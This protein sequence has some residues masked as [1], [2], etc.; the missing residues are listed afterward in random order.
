MSKTEK[1]PDFLPLKAKGFPDL[2]YGV[3]VGDELGEDPTCDIW[4]FFDEILEKSEGLEIEE[5]DA[6]STEIITEIQEA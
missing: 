5:I 2:E 6:F 1:L 4:E 3:D